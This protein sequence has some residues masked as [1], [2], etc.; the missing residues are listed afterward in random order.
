MAKI[1]EFN[2]KKFKNADDL[3][4]FYKLVYEKGS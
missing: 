2:E 3:I 1:I 4:D